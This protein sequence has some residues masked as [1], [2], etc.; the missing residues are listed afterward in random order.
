MIAAGMSAE[1]A[2]AAVELRDALDSAGVR[3]YGVR[4]DPY[5]WDDQRHGPL[6][7]VRLGSVHPYAARELADL[8]RRGATP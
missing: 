5:V 6:R 8:I 3:M 4:V 2:R 1:A 7:L